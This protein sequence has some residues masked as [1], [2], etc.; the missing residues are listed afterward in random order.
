MQVE[1]IYLD[2]GL[3]SVAGLQVP[4]MRLH[5]DVRPEREYDSN[6]PLKHPA[7]RA[8]EFYD[9]RLSDDTASAFAS[10]SA[11]SIKVL[12]EIIPFCTM[13]MHRVNAYVMTVHR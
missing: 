5:E 6:F 12:P 13:Y 7:V 11:S 4:S 3:E 9:P 8:V 10:A 1:D 2:D